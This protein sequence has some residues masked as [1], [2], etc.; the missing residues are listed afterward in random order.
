ASTT[1]HLVVQVDPA[2]TSDVSNT[3]TVSGD[4]SDPDH[5]NDS[6][7]VTTTVT[8]APPP[9]PSADLAVTKSASPD[10]FNAGDDLT[11]TIGVSNDGPS[12]A[13]GVT[14]SDP[15]PAGTSFVSA[16]SGGSLS[17]GTVTWSIGALASGASTTVH[18]VVQVDPAQT[19]D[20]SNTATVTGDQSAP[21]APND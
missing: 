15:I 12:D 4:Q 5:S 7:N 21:N 8:P 10:P 1:V 17:A 16:D 6:A 2:Q 20:V 3:A 11:Y 9:P 18:L 14:L 19:S 13:T